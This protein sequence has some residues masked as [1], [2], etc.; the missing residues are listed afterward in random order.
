MNAKQ[1]PFDEPP[2]IEDYVLITLLHLS[3]DCADLTDTT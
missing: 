1:A 3:K 2:N